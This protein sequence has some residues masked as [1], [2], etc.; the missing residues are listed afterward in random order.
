MGFLTGLIMPFLKIVFKFLM[1]IGFY[2]FFI[3]LA[4]FLIYELTPYYTPLKEGTFLYFVQDKLVYISFALM[5][6]TT[7]QNIIRMI[8]KN[9]SFRLWNLFTKNQKAKEKAVKAPK[10]SNE[11]VSAKPEGFTFGKQGANYIRKAITM[12]GHILTIGGAGS[13]KSSCVAIPSLISWESRVF[14]VDIKGE[15]SAKTGY[16]RPNIKVFNPMS[17]DSDGYNPYYLLAK[18][19]NPVQDAREITLAIIPTPAN[20]KE[21]FWIES[22]QNIFTGAILHFFGQGYTF[23]Q[24]INAVQ[25]T[26]IETLISAIHSSPTPDAKYFVNQLVGMDLKTL[27]GIFSELSNKIMP[28]AT[29]PDIKTCLA[30]RNCITPEDIERGHDIYLNI[31]EDKIEQ[32][33]GLLTLIINQFL[34]HFER[35]PDTDA[36]PVL[37]LLDEFK[38]LGK[39]ETVINGLATLRSKKVTI[40]ILTQSLADL[41]VIYTADQR[42][43]IADNCQYK[44]ILNATDADT[45]D[46]FSRLVGTYDKAKFSKSSNFE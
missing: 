36:I 17:S 29:D 22:A 27:A 3:G 34:K 14:A 28:F 33:K 31:P 38:R 30:K 40:C 39:I 25:S 23:P 4:P 41:D 15:L 9:N 32:W 2:W 44:A 19:R 18:S 45:Q 24:T 12:D 35:R 5:A 26:P 6:L 46:Y 11:L 37:F 42:K 8:T 1:F 20:V 16:K 43:V 7:I 13:G 21:P 10:A